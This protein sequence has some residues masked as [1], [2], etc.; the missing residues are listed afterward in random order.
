MLDGGCVCLALVCHPIF[1]N[2]FYFSVSLLLRRTNRGPNGV[3]K[4]ARYLRWTLNR[5]YIS[6][7]TSILHHYKNKWMELSPVDNGII[8]WSFQ[9]VF[10]VR[11]FRSFFFFFFG[12]ILKYWVP[13]CIESIAQI[14]IGCRFRIQLGNWMEEKNLRC[15]LFFFLIKMCIEKVPISGI[16]HTFVPYFQSLLF[17]TSVEREK[18]RREHSKEYLDG[19]S[20]FILRTIE[21]VRKIYCKLIAFFIW[22]M[23]MSGARDYL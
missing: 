4:T 20:I 3:W 12:F 11:V 2:I 18:K 10:C 23:D 1:T 13:Y 14:P 22:N 21:F 19:R 8:L 6:D 5:A 16:A 9:T 7:Q 15:Y 17:G